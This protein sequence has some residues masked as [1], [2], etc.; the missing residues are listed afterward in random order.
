MILDFNM[1]TKRINQLIDDGAENRATDKR[2]LEY[3]INKFLH[4][5][6]RKDM[7]TGWNYYK[8]KHDILKTKRTI[9]G[10]DGKLETVD[11]LPNNRIVDNQY[12]KLVDQKN[13]YILGKGISFDCE[14]EYEELLNKVLGSKFQRTLK[15]IGKDS[16]NCG[17]GWLYI[18]YDENGEFNFKR[19]RPY[20]IL[21]FWKDDDH[22]ELAF[23]V[24][25]YTV[26]FFNGSIEKE[27]YKVEVY[28]KDGIHRFDYEDGKLIEDV[29]IAY[30][31]IG[32][33]S[34][35]WNRIPLI[36]F[37][38]N[39]NEIP[40]IKKA[41]CI[42][43][44]INSIVSDFKNCMEENTSGSSII[45]LKNYDGENLSEF[46]KN[47]STFR[48]IKIKDTIDGLNGDVQTLEIKVNAEN[49][50]SLLT[51]FKKAMIENCKGY[52]INEL[53]S[54]GSPNEMTIKAVFSDIDLD[55]NELETEYQA[56]LEQF[57]WF[58]N[59]HLSKNKNLI[60]MPDVRVIF[61]RD[62]MINE[63]QVITDIKNSYGIL[64]DKTL[65]S[66]HPY[67]KNINEELKRIE[68]QQNLKVY[69]FGDN[70]DE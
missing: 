35:S 30:V 15:N 68:E 58:V 23:A 66:M 60:N 41:K 54:N 13:N 25:I 51:M 56:S 47:L 40:L 10:Q 48:A 45:I 57:L 1:E 43:D 33:T 12:G 65:I 14:E 27:Q 55:A 28:A 26:S 37:K 50:T 31:E 7:I 20:E 11:N 64:S 44:G 16:L 53:K 36:A 61:D 19:F 3:H 6:V 32:E 24:R 22:T 17:I 59:V 8:G 69:N 63:S 62:L 21:P 5:P 38:S 9:L 4:S 70:E 2:F 29:S 49:Y 52:D 67:T 42:Q 39:G 34:Y 18:Y 46:R